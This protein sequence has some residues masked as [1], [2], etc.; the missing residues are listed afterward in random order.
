MS[1]ISIIIPVLNEA[2]G[3]AEAMHALQPLRARGHEVIVVDGGSGDATVAI[4]RPWVD[5]IVY[6][7]RGRAMQMNAGSA[8]A[9]HPV[10]LFLHADTRLPVNAD[11][12]LLAHCR[13]ALDARWGR[14]D[15]RLSGQAKLLR[16]VEFMMNWRSRL[17]GIATGDQAIFVSRALFDSAGGYPEIALM[18]DLALSRRLKQRA[19]PCCLRKRVESSSRRWE[20]NG[21]FRTILMMWHLR[22]AHYFGANPRRLEEIYAGQRQ[23]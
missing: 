17:T 23:R 11:R 10:L 8:I 18:E 6:S 7:R 9:R 21:I 2:A 15:V 5:H 16:V 19:R 12:L 22:L 1:K 3:I 14:F 4:V 13:D 20:K